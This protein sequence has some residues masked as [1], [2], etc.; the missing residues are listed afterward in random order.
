[1]RAKPKRARAQGIFETIM[2][3]GL[4]QFFDPPFRIR[5]PESGPAALLFNSPHSG[6]IYPEA[7]LAA[8]RLDPLALRRSEDMDVDHLFARHRCGRVFDDGG[9]P[10]RLL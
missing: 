2:T 1:M 5:H 7:F 8:S 6:R 9:I 10:A 3:T 4:E